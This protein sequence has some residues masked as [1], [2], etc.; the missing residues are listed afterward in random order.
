MVK[1]HFI[2]QWKRRM[3]EQINLPKNLLN[4]LMIKCY[5]SVET[6]L[7]QRELVVIDD[8]NRYGFEL[9]ESQLCVIIENGYLKT[10]WRRNVNS[11]KT[12][13]G[14][15]VDNVRFEYSV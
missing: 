10:M 5:K 7:C 2:T 8:I 4:E 13:Y 11:P 3:E 9:D 12:T 14:S 1:T 15:K 6:N